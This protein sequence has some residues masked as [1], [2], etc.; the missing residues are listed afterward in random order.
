MEER[1]EQMT[2]KMKS[3]RVIKDVESL[4]PKIRK[5]LEM[6]YGDRLVDIFLYG[7]FARNNAAKESDIDI[8]VVLKGE[9]NKTKEI[10]RIYDVLYD[11]ML[12]SNELISVYPLSKEEIENPIWP[13]FYHIRTEGIRI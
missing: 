13:L 9:V 2:D 6:I 8:A 10:D 3:G 5:V 4:L 7:S 12:E 1:D 11:L